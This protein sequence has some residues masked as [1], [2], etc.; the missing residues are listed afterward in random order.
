MATVLR[1]SRALRACE[2]FQV[3]TPGRRIGTVEEIWLGPH[4]EPAA[5]AVR[6][7]DG[8]HGLLLLE[9]VAV[10]SAETRTV[11]MER[12]ARLLELRPPRLDPDD[13]APVHASWATTGETLEVPPPPGRLERAGLR[14]APAE[15]VERPLWA[16]IALLYVSLAVVVGVVLGLVFVV[17]WLAAGQPY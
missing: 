9:D 13:G 12:G 15:H 5:L 6:T 3:E 4:D 7:H 17:S 11:V 14:H 8:C 2:G 10:A 1:H 16:T